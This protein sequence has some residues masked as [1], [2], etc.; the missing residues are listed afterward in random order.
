MKQQLREW[1]NKEVRLPGPKSK[2]I[3]LSSIGFGLFVAVFLMI[4]QPF[5]LFEIKSS[6]KYLLIFLY[7]PL[8]TLV[9]LFFYSFLPAI[10]KPIFNIWNNLKELVYSFVVIFGISLCNWLYTGLLAKESS[11]YPSLLGFFFITLAVGLFPMIFYA[12]Y[13]ERKAMKNRL[14]TLG[15][16]EPDSGIS[17]LVKVKSQVSI[18]TE[19]NQS[20]NIDADHFF[21][22]KSLGNYCSVF[23]LEDGIVKNEMLRVS[24]LNIE[25]QVGDLPFILRCHK[26]YIVNLE[27]VQ[28]V[29]GN[30]RGYKLYI[31]DLDFEV[32]VSRNISLDSLK[33]KGMIVK[34]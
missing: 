32:P 34:D 15:D 17:N 10:L 28:K 8:T 2:E 19:N 5:H 7:G 14:K 25:Q 20:L 33:E 1:F 11:Q 31:P 4:F 12:L 23:F 13:N 6:Y 18:V 24:M 29:L 22:V 3:Y 21:C 26:S 9:I 30:S 27:T 16:S